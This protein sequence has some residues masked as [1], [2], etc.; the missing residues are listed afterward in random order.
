MRQSG[1]TS[2]PLSFGEGQGEGSCENSENGQADF[3]PKNP[4]SNTPL[5]GG[6]L[7]NLDYP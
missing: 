3:A 4:Y 7:A 2:A 1:G 5:K 6:H